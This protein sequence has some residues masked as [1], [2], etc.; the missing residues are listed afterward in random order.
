MTHLPSEAPYEDLFF[1]QTVAGYLDNP[2]FFRRDWLV[3][4]VDDHLGEA[5]CRFILLTA[6]PGAGKSAFVAQLASD[7][8]QRPVYFIRR[9]QRTPLADA[10]AHSFLLRIGYQLAANYPALFEPE[11]LKVTISQRVGSLAAGGEAVGAEVKRVLASPF[12]RRVVQIRQEFDRSEGK[13]VGL[14]VGEW[15]VEPHLLPLNDL[16]HMALI[17]PALTLLREQPEKQLVILVDA[18]DELTYQPDGPTLLD[19]LANSPQLPANIRFVLTSRPPDERLRLFADK[20][21]P[22]LRT[23]TIDPGSERIGR[24]LRAY[25]AQLVSQPELVRLATA[26]GRPEGDFVER[27]VDKAE[28]NIGYLDAVARALDHALATSPPDETLILNLLQLRALPERLGGLYA[29]FLG[30]IRSSLSQAERPTWAVVY[31]PLLGVLAVAREPVTLAQLRRMAGLEEGELD[32]LLDALERLRPFLDLSPDQRMRFYHATLPEFLTDP[33]TEQNLDTAAFYCDPARWHSQIVAGYKGQYQRIAGATP[34]IGL[35]GSPEDDPTSATGDGYFWNHYAHHLLGAS[36]TIALYELI[37]QLW[38][39]A[40]F[41]QFGRHDPFLADV[42][43]AIHTAWQAR[44]ANL[45][46]MIRCCAAYSLC[47][48][49][50]PPIVIQVLAAAGQADRAKTM[51]A[52]IAFAVDRCLAYSLLAQTFAGENAADARQCLDE[53][54]RN[55]PVID[56]THRGMVWYWIGRAALKMGDPSQAETA[57]QEALATALSLQADSVWEKPNAL[58]WAAMALRQVGDQDGLARLRQAFGEA[59]LPLVRNLTLQTMSVAGDLE[60]LRQAAAE[61]TADANFGGLRNLS[62]LALALADAGLEVERDQVLAIIGQTVGEAGSYWGEPDAH[63]RY[64]WA[65]ALAGRFDQ[66]LDQAGQIADVQ[67]RV[68]A[69]QRVVERAMGAGQP[70]AVDRALALAD[71]VSQQ[72][73]WRLQSRLASLFLAGGRVDRAM[74]LAEAVCDQDIPTTVD[75][76]LT[77]PT[78]EGISRP[79]AGIIQAAEKEIDWEV[80]ADEMSPGSGKRPGLWDRLLQKLGREKP[81]SLPLRTTPAV[82]TGK[83]PL[84]TEVRPVPDEE[85][86]GEVARLAEAG[87]WDQA[88]ARLDEIHIPQYRAQALRAMA[89]QAEQS[90]EGMAYWLQAIYEARQ[91]GWNSLE[92]TIEIEE[93]VFDEL[94]DEESRRRI[95]ER[96]SQVKGWWA[97]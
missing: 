27:V 85:E 94:L 45:E 1:R 62:N 61:M 11:K 79:A 31:K 37:N 59:D 15:V 48:T 18:L 39:Q 42:D 30:Q 58:F 92:K 52:N 17:D 32:P 8:P 6:E 64:V 65:L 49:S 29:F 76:T 14:R 2:R 20:Q 72:G 97:S 34:E 66:A 73:D 78:V 80:L 55:L 36:Q 74:T 40:K 86:A 69:L 84:R 54:R 68:K 16:Q 22:Y 35:A 26:A 90:G 9:D 21:A 96:V 95:R 77:F 67:E 28:G 19:W 25:A 91:A 13:A 83:Q 7:D 87:E 56:D 75:N 70:Q 81:A 41:S 38:M 10:G 63:K 89:L 60:S 4:E 23:I 50:A 47:V 43:L 71:S 93:G 88:K 5:D 82:K 12:Y 3:A 33:A 57:A 51:A 44:P 53:V 46:E 24:E